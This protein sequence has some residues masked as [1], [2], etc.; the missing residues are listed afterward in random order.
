[1][2]I[3]APAA[4]IA[5]V[6]SAMSPSGY[7]SA[8]DTLAQTPVYTRIYTPETMVRRIA[9]GRHAGAPT[10]GLPDQTEQP[11]GETI[12]VGTRTYSC[13]EILDGNLQ[14]AGAAWTHV[15]LPLAF[16]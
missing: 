16:N 9:A 2:K 14:P 4:L 11:V 8:Q 15:I 1:M 12:R 3:I 7:L 13:V 6:V 10:C 5:L